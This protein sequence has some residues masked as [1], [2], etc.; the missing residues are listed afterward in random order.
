MVVTGYDSDHSDHW[1]RQWSL[2]WHPPSV[3]MADITNQL[4]NPF[5]LRPGI[6]SESPSTYKAPK[7]QQGLTI[8]GISTRNKSYLPNS[9]VRGDS[10]GGLH[11]SVTF[12]RHGFR[13]LFQLYSFMAPNWNIYKRKRVRIARDTDVIGHYVLSSERRHWFTARRNARWVS[14]SCEEW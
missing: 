5:L 9:S 14:T 1:L 8:V 12:C 2:R 13:I 6:A 4:W 10:L 3:P 7:S 11:S